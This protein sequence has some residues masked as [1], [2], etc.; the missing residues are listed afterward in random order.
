M[1]MLLLKKI[2]SYSTTYRLYEEVLVQY[3][4][5]SKVREFEYSVHD[6]HQVGQDT[7]ARVPSS[8]QHGDVCCAL[9]IGQH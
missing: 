4:D 7:R 8:H 6:P 2:V 5:Y 9:V 1:H 3:A